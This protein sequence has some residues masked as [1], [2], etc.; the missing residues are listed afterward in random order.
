MATQSFTCFTSLPGEI[1]KR[2]W[3]FA[4]ENVPELVENESERLDLDFLY[5]IYLR[6]IGEVDKS[7]L[8]VIDTDYTIVKNCFATFLLQTLLAM[9]D[10]VESIKIY[11]DDDDDSGH[12]W[13]TI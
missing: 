13:E 10:A 11:D 6:P 9:R 3:G 7:F 12:D 5:N 1:E 8:D 4:E 2:I